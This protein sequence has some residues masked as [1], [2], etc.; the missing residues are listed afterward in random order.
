MKLLGALFTE[1]SR[2]HRRFHQS[3]FE[4]VGI[5]RGQ[6]E[7]FFTLSKEKAPINQSSLAKKLKMAPS[8]LTRMA[9]SLEKK[10]YVSRHSDEKDQRQTL[11]SLTEEGRKIQKAIQSQFAEMDEGIFKD[12]NDEE[13]QQLRGYLLRI[14][15]SI[16][17]EQEKK[18]E[19]KE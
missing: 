5:Y 14:Q 13:K 9:Q 3:I 17:R 1:T 18:G 19:I 11:I 16:T 8:T 7:L 6:P 12:F 10:G 15:E 4:S 2:M